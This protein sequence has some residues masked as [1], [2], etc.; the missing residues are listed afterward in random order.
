MCSFQG[1]VLGGTRHPFVS[2]LVNREGLLTKDLESYTEE[3]ASKSLEFCPAHLT[4][5]SPVGQLGRGGNGTRTEHV[6]FARSSLRE[7]T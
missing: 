5:L 3:K 7:R 2:L 4:P 6:V 1:I